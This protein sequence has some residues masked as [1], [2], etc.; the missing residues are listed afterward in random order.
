MMNSTLSDVQ[1]GIEA[2]VWSACAG[3]TETIR[4]Q[5][6]QGFDL[7]RIDRLGDTIL[8]CVI[9]EV[10]ICSATPRYEVIRE[11]LRL[12]ADPLLLSHD[13]SNP[14]FTAVLHMDSEMLRILLDAGADPNQ[15]LQIPLA[16]GA[17]ADAWSADAMDESLYDWAEFAYCHEVWQGK[18]PETANAAEMTDKDACLRF[19][20]RLAVSHGKRRPDHLQLLRDCG[21]R[22]LS[23]ME[24][25]NCSAR[26]SI[27]A[28]DES[29]SMN[30]LL[31]MYP[32]ACPDRT[33]SASR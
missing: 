15:P 13:G 23:E 5:V 7:N 10:E 30:A 26:Q 29:R 11:I 4:A 25:S 9:S 17:D 2:F 1:E 19:L 12:G 6:A 3:D 31:V 24:R 8:E 27:A 33:V 14:L 18:L 32:P 28:D 20:D 21:A 22:S 16:A